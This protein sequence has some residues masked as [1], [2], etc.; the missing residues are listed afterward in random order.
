[1]ACATRGALH[2]DVDDDERDRR[3]DCEYG[4]QPSAGSSY[5]VRRHAYRMSGEQRAEEK[6]AKTVSGEQEGRSR[7]M[8]VA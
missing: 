4:V 6:K 5:D 8:Y 7:I 1:M 3:A 2:A